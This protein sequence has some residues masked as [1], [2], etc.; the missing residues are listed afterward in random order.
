MEYRV[1]IEFEIKLD[2][3]VYIGTT[4]DT[5]RNPSPPSIRP[6]ASPL[7][8]A[9]LALS[10]VAFYDAVSATAAEAA[11]P[12]R[13]HPRLL[14][15]H[16]PPP[17]TEAPIA[18]IAPTAAHRTA[19]PPEQTPVQ[20]ALLNRTRVAA[21][22]ASSAASADLLAMLSHADFSMTVRMCGGSALADLS[23]SDLLAR[24]ERELSVV[25]V[26]H[27][28][29]WLSESSEHVALLRTLPFL[30]NHWTLPLL[31]PYSD[32]DGRLRCWTVSDV[33]NPGNRSACE[34]ATWDA[35]KH[36]LPCK[37]ESATSQCRATT[38][39]VEDQS[40]TE[41][42]GLPSFRAEASP[43]GWSEVCEELR[44]ETITLNP[45]APVTSSE[46]TPNPAPSHP[47]LHPP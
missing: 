16:T 40:E 23:P 19:L 18:P 7:R 38:F 8:T 32:R 27:S 30:P 33:L 12:L 13:I 45:P 44:E 10:V 9:C 4:L 41:T 21:S 46:P 11:R 39:D 37:W 36:S 15:R 2:F 17:F 1:C 47:P 20:S 34:D 5:S 43:A 26:A 31:P 6:M 24:I 25:E 22:A 28:F 3:V 29:G 14:R 42:Y 35:A